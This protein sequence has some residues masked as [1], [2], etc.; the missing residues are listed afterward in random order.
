M[1]SYPSRAWI[2]MVRTQLRRGCFLP[3][4]SAVYLMTPFVVGFRET[5][6]YYVIA[7]C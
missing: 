3:G 1:R 2:A 5:C 7:Q 6:H 4:D